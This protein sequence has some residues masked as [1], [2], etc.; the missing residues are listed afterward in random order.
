M[1][2]I[3]MAAIEMAAERPTGALRG[4]APT[5]VCHPSLGE[6]RACRQNAT[7][8]SMAIRNIPYSKTKPLWESA[9][10]LGPTLFENQSNPPPKEVH[11]K[12]RQQR[13]FHF[14]KLT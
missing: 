5:F 11:R 1:A 8:S 9:V 10:T 2:A 6:D 3:E 14:L 7:Y 13:K 4:F 12:T